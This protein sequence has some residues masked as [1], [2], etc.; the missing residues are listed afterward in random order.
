MLRFAQILFAMSLLF[1][2]N[3]YANANGEVSGT[4]EEA[5]CMFQVPD[6]VEI[7]CGYLTVPENYDDPEGTQIRLAVA[8]LRHPDGNP[9]PDPI[10]YLEGGPGGSVLELLY[11]T[12]PQI[13]EPMFA[14]NRDIILFD[15]RGVGASEPALDCDAARELELDLLDYEFE[16]NP[17][18]LAEALELVNEA[19]EDCGASLAQANDLTQYNSANN[20][21]DVEALRTALGYDQVNLWGISYGTRLGLTVMRDYPEGIR[22]V[23]LD[24]LVPLEAEFEAV[25]ADSYNR[26]LD[27]LFA[28]CAADEACSAAYPDLEEVYFDTIDALNE[29]PAVFDA[30]N[31]LTGVEYENIRFTGYNFSQAIFQLLYSTELLPAL[32]Q[33]IYETAAGDVEGLRTYMS[34][35]FVNLEVISIGMNRA[36]NCYEERPFIETEAF[37]EAFTTFP[38]YTEEDAQLEAES[39]IGICDAFQTGTAPAIEDEPVVSDLPTLVVSGEYDPVTPPAF[40]EQVDSSLTNST[41]VAFPAA[42][43]GPTGTVACPRQVAVDFFNDPAAELDTSCVDEMNV[44]FVVPAEETTEVSFVPLDLTEYNINATTVIPESWTLIPAPGNTVVYGRQE[45]ALDQTAVTMIPLPGVTSV[46]Q[47]TTALAAQFDIGDEAQQIVTTPDYEWSIFPLEVQGFGGSL[48]VS[49]DDAGAIVVLLI[50]DEA[51][52]DTVLIPMLEAFDPVE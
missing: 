52:R 38:G 23:V 39:Y 18:D 26:A 19:Y 42:G 6:G 35:S 7:D 48:A 33:I 51:I 46:Q 22:S 9:E 45:T 2:V 17:V 30:T 12:Y 50:G 20:A 47:V 5:S 14:A 15:Q 49:L 37:V 41:Y 11:L 10:L 27:V 4:F 16:G 8:I 3:M 36:V 13:Y 43:H 28:D 25:V 34:I 31:P 29:A 40:A 32:P 21:A 1:S 24:S 44:D